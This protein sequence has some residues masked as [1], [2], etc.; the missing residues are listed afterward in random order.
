MTEETIKSRTLCT[1][2]ECKKMR[3]KYKY[4]MEG[5]ENDLW[6]KCINIVENVIV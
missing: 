4:M 2:D 6:E 3:E 5:K 1:N